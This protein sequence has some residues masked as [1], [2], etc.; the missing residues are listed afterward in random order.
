VSVLLR[1]AEHETVRKRRSAR[2]GL[3]EGSPLWIRSGLVQ[4]TGE[5]TLVAAPGQEQPRTVRMD[6]S[7]PLR[8][9]PRSLAQGQE[10]E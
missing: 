6:V 5:Q 10:P 7:S 3:I 4:E 9:R 2:F 1:Q 8:H